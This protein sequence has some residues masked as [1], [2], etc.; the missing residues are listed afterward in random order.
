MKSQKQQHI[1][2]TEWSS[3]KIEI[4]NPK[5]NTTEET[6]NNSSKSKNPH[7]IYFTDPNQKQRFKNY[8]QQT[9]EHRKII[10]SEHGYVEETE[11]LEE[12]KKV[13][14]GFFTW[15]DEKITSKQYV[16][17]LCF[18]NITIEIIPKMIHYEN[19]NWWHNLLFWLEYTNS[20]ALPFNK[21]N[22]DTYN[23]QDSFLEILIS[24]FAYYTEPII[25]HQPY[26]NYQSVT[27]ETNF[28]KGSLD[29]PK[30]I[31]NNLI[32]GRWHTFTCNYKPFILDNRLNQ[33]IK[34]VTTRLLT[35]TKEN[36]NREKLESILFIL[37]EVGFR[38]CTINDCNQVHLNIILKSIKLY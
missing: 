37:N 3:I 25:S 12:P 21:A 17:V 38:E 34:Y 15:Y 14:E 6:Q 30:Y 11:D 31:Q 22:L 10:P 23:N 27:E 7:T 1:K 26:Q 33:I 28:L 36:Y 19:K 20:I 35:I 4:G 2:I 29:I 8:L 32:T 9:W 5:D 13:K 24:I 16:G 18:E